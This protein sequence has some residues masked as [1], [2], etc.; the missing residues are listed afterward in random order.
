MQCAWYWGCWNPGEWDRHHNLHS[1]IDQNET[2]NIEQVH[3]QPVGPGF[4]FLH[5][6]DPGVRLEDRQFPTG[7]TLELHVL[8]TDRKR[9]FHLDRNCEFG[10]ESDLHHA[11][12][13]REDRS[14]LFPSE[15]LP[16]LDDVCGNGDGLDDRNHDR[17]ASGSGHY[18]LRRRDLQWTD[19]LAARD[20][21]VHLQ[22]L[23]IR[24]RL[25]SACVV[26]HFLLLAHPGD[27]EDQRWILQ[28]AE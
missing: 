21:W 2:D 6:V 23:F 26:I 27:D 16:E 14:Q 24:H 4:I 15:L 5:V 11:R 18:R 9:D 25:R 8:S 7:Q 22:H 28:R 19:H 3:P 1:W 20:Q 10:D 13:V 12:K 17:H